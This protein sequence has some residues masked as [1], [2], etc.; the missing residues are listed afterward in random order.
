MLVRLLR[1]QPGLASAGEIRARLA[2]HLTATNLAVEAAYFDP[3]TI[4]VSSDVWLAWRCGWRG[5]AAVE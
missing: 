4:A 3:R 1:T 2:A 5:T